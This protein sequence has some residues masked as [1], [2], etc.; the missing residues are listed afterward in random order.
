MSGTSV[1]AC[2][3]NVWCVVGLIHGDLPLFDTDSLIYPCLLLFVWLSYAPWAQLRRA[4]L[5]PHCYYYKSG[6]ISTTFPKSWLFFSPL[7]IFH[8]PLSPC[9]STKLHDHAYSNMEKKWHGTSGHW[10]CNCLIAALVKS[11][12]GC[13]TYCCSCSW[14]PC[15]P[16]SPSSWSLDRCR[17]STACPPWSAVHIWPAVCQS[18]RMCEWTGRTGSQAWPHLPESPAST[19]LY[20]DGKSWVTLHHIITLFMVMVRIG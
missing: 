8:P 12:K 13:T 15:A 10:H 18:G 9:L 20:V 5:R 6:N 7:H 11:H 3:Q 14:T 4:A 19:S 17:R 2:L 1:F 16:P